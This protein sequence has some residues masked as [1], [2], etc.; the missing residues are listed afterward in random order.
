MPCTSGAK[1]L[2]VAEFLEPADRFLQQPICGSVTPLLAPAAMAERLKKV[3]ELLPPNP[4]FEF[5][6]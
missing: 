2:I 3:S 5:A 6:V 1:A 4:D